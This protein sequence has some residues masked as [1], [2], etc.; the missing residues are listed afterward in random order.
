MSN[1]IA[2]IDYVAN[3]AARSLRSGRCRRIAIF[4]LPGA[5]TAGVSLLPQLE[6]TIRK[7]GSRP[8]VRFLEDRDNLDRSVLESTRMVADCAIIMHPLPGTL[9]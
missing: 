7:A 1:A 9:R 6:A 8:F 2:G 3:N 5:K 4:A